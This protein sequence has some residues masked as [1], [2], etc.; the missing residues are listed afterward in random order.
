[1][2]CNSRWKEASSARPYKSLEHAAVLKVSEIV[3]A[4][5]YDFV[6]HPLLVFA[7][8]WNYRSVALASHT[9]T[10]THAVKERRELL[11]PSIR[12]RRRTMVSLKL[13][14]RG[15]PSAQC[16]DLRRGSCVAMLI[17]DR[18]NCTP[19]VSSDTR[20]SLNQPDS[21]PRSR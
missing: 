6:G 16:P 21:R 3:G 12:L 5:T 19:N 18:E 9:A 11:N 4:A 10:K 2:Q 7:T 17:L 20:S 15:V 1:M 8:P 14:S 13:A